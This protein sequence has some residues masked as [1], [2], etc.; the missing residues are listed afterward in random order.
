MSKFVKV[1]IG[2]LI[3]TLT[4]ACGS[5]SS[6]EPKRAPDGTYLNYPACNQEYA[7]QRN[8]IMVD[9]TNVFLGMTQSQRTEGQHQH[10]GY[11]IDPSQRRE[12]LYNLK[13]RLGDF[14]SMYQNVICLGMVPT[15]KPGFEQNP[16]CYTNP[17]QS[18][19]SEQKVSNEF[20]AKAYSIL[21]AHLSRTW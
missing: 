15:C 14:L 11:N 7:Y 4:V 17:H 16:Y 18:Q 12:N 19:L 21:E 10:L 9:V 6:Q 5:N 1:T 20:L 13:L 3:L 8:Q 2:A